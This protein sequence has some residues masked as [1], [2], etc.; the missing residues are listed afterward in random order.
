VIMQ[1]LRET[2]LRSDCEVPVAACHRQVGEPDG[3]FRIEL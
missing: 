3:F 1:P 2:H